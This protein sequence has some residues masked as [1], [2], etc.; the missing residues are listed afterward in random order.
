MARVLLTFTLFFFFNIVTIHALSPV[1]SRYVEHNMTIILFI[2]VI[3][4]WAYVTYFLFQNTAVK[5]VTQKEIDNIDTTV[6]LIYICTT[7][8]F[9]E[10]TIT[11]FTDSLQRL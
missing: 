11:Y 9:N 10:K 1:I 6:V 4:H 5:K 7:A 2:V 8:A 3:N